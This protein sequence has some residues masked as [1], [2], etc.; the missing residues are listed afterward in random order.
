MGK[1]FFPMPVHYTLEID[2][3]QYPPSK[4]P[5]SAQTLFPSNLPNTSPTHPWILPF[6]YGFMHCGLLTLGFLP[7]PV[8]RGLWRDIVSFVPAI[9]KWMPIDEFEDVHRQLGY[10]FFAMVG[11][12]AILWIVSM[13]IDCLNNFRDV[14]LTFDPIVNHF[15]DPVE[16]VLTLR[17]VVWSTWFTV[18]PLMAFAFET[19]PFGLI[20]ITP[21]RK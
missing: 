6:I 20:K 18:L 17:F 14:C 9:K 4:V 5:G 1:L 7:L 16:N 11:A 2:P 12:G 19:P 13:S 10:L 21:I 15:E 8:S 3:L